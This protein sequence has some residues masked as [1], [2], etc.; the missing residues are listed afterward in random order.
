MLCI[1]SGCAKSLKI[2]RQ[3]IRMG[4]KGGETDLDVEFE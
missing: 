1:E 2:S 4:V 3:E